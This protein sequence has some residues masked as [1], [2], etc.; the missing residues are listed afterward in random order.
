LSIYFKTIKNPLENVA[1]FG[2]LAESA[3]TGTLTVT[4]TQKEQ[5]GDLEKEEEVVD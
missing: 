5:R 4:K 2:Q 1:D 3:T